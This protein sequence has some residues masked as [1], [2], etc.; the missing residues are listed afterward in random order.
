MLGLGKLSLLF[1]HDVDA[2]MCKVS[3]MSAPS[4][5][6]GEMLMMGA[7]SFG[8]VLGSGSLECGMV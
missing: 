7:A 4:A 8:C 1:D 5:W 3:F 2:V 6:Y